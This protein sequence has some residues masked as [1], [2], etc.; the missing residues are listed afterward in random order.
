MTAHLSPEQLSEWVLGDRDPKTVQ[1]VGSCTNCQAQI[2]QFEA[3][4]G[5]FRSSVRTWSEDQLPPRPRASQPQARRPYAWALRA[6]WVLAACVLAVLVVHEWS[7]IK[8][9]PGGVSPQEEAA[10]FRQIDQETSRTI[11]AAMD[12]LS[13]LVAGDGARAAANKT[14]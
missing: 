7:Q 1:H 5:G 13:K 12:P 8:I 14:P 6:E 9:V 10:L 3:A 4:L 11:P 2:E